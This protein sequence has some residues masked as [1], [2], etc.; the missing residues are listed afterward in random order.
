[1]APSDV[2]EP[3]FPEVN[4]VIEENVTPEE[5]AAEEPP[6]APYEPMPKGDGEDFRRYVEEALAELLRRSS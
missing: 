4:V 5:E 3:Y 2:E 6:A 1:M